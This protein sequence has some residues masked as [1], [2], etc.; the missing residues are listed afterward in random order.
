MISYLYNNMVYSIVQNIGEIKLK[1]IKSSVIFLFLLILTMGVVCAEDANQTAQDTLELTD[2]QDV[3]SDASEK[4]FTDL[5]D[6]INK[7]D[8]AITLENDY[9]YDE[10]DTIK[11]I[12]FKDNF[13]INGNNHVIDADGK[14]F[15][16]KVSEGT[17]TLKN[18]ILKN[19]ND[20]AI[21]VNSG[22]VTVNVTFMNTNSADFGGAV[23]C[24]GGE[25]NST[26]DRFIDASAQ[27]SGSAIFAKDSQLVMD[28]ATFTN[29]NP[30]TWSLIYGSS[31]NIEIS[32]SVFANI[33]SKYAT[34]IYNSGLTTVKKSKFIN[35]TAN[36]TAGAIAIKGGN[37]TNYTYLTVDECEFINVSAA[38][39]GG[40]IFADINGDGTNCNGGLVN[41]QN[42]LFDKNSAE[43]GGALLQLGG[44]LIV[45]NSTF[46][47]NIVNENGGAIY[48]SNATVII[49]KDTFTN[50]KANEN[51]G[52]GG[53]VLLDFEIATIDNCTFT[54]NVASEGGAIYSYSTQYK[55]MNSQFKNNGKD[56]YTRFDDEGSNITNCGEYTSTIDDRSFNYIVRYNGEKII[57]DPRPI[58]GSAKDSYFNLN[59]LGLVT[60]VKNQGSMGSCW[61][62]GAAGAFESSFLIATGKEID[63]SENNIQNLGLRYSIYGMIEEIEGGTLHMSA[64]YFVSWFGATNTLED[65]YDELGKISKIPYSPDGAY[66][67]VNA[68][69]IDINDMDAIKQYLTKY[70]ALNLFVY[71]AD[72]RDPSYSNKYKS[73]YN[74]KYN[75]NHY[76][77]LVGWDDN[78]S[79]N[80]FSTPAPGN[81][82]WICKNS[83]G[84]DWGDGG[85]FYISYYD[86]SLKANAV[87]F[88]FDNV[89]FYEKLY[90]NEVNGISGYSYNYDTYGQIYSSENGD[91]IAAV[92]TYFENANTPYTISIFLNNRVAYSQSGK[93]THAGYETIKLDKYVAVDPN[94]T[95]EIRI[96][97]SSMPYVEG[98]RTAHM[99][100]VNYAVDNGKFVDLS[101]KNMVAS[102]KAYTYHSPVITKDVVKYFDNNETIFTVYNVTEADIIQASFQDKNYTIQI[103]NGTGSISL[104]VLPAGEYLVTITYKNQTFSSMVLVK[105]TIFSDDEKSMNVAYNAKSSF[106]VQFFD[107]NGTPLAN[108]LVTAKFDNEVIKGAKTD[109]NGTLTIGI[110]PKN[111]IGKHYI[112]Y[113]N[114]ETGEQ[115]RITINVLSRFAGNSNVNMYYYD[116]HSYKVRVRAD[117]GQFAGKNQLVTIKIG[118]KTFKVRTNA[119][120]YAILKIPS[121]VT[122]GKYTIAATYKGQTVKNKLTVKQVLKTKKTVTVKKSAKKLVLSATLKKGKTALKSKVV[123]F[124]VNGKTYKARTNKK[125]IAKVTIKKAAINKLKVKKYTVKVSYLNDAVKSTLN[126]RR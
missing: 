92:G 91:I 73:I 61:A 84:T 45:T 95:F 46:T 96:Q 2:T 89:E 118:K 18:L 62:F 10:K 82:A 23:Y 15:M 116:G 76:V 47:N 22:L 29:K 99:T 110:D 17:L 103:S 67:T 70:G 13:T 124:K 30:I 39:N 79:K 54:D 74:S 104:G 50:N 36:A 100:G 24:S 12:E 35:L 11:Y 125:G 101:N 26:D 41:I 106:T 66:R 60:P 86:A 72:L 9:K 94:S 97:S 69:Y 3:I 90:Q 33:A 7:T 59:D 21:Q 83:W 122:P 42:T 98:M 68:V 5:F 80:N 51:D 32:N 87:G 75:G 93:S 1:L 34:A 126:V 14:T 53:A 123:K 112:D 77:T 78:F 4:S 56:I 48:T 109:A 102:V 57:L 85:Y 20:S 6:A 113:A 58:N 55:I 64:A 19:T 121:K 63:I 28:N 16:F 37:P 120:G 108:T 115:L 119:N 38:R 107:S 31:S 8:D 88:T 114:P 71:G 43:F 117:N 65:S 111:E 105:T 40:A 52:Y 25:F 81:G 27:G 44:V 49:N